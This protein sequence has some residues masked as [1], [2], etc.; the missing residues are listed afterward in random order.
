MNQQEIKTIV[1][2]ILVDMLLISETEIK[3]DSTFK[4]LGAD[5]L[6]EVEIILEVERKFHISI[7]EEMIPQVLSVE[8]LSNYIEKKIKEQST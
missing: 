8:S 4:D 5:S 7:S 2:D 3:P 1:S 6:D